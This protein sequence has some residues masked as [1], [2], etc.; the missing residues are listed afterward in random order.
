MNRAGNVSDIEA[1]DAHCPILQRLS[2]HFEH[3][4][5]ELGQLIEEQEPV[6]RK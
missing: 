3:V 5:R 1:R 2:Q 4:P 6:M